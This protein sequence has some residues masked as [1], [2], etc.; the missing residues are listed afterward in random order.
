MSVSRPPPNWAL[1]FPVCEKTSY[2]DLFRGEVMIR[3]YCLDIICTAEVPILSP[4][5]FPPLAG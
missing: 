3:G 4:L 1:S 2:F 5:P